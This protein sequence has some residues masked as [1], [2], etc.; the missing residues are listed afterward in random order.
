MKLPKTICCSLWCCGLVLALVALSGPNAARAAFILEIDT[1]GADDGILTFNPNFSFGGDTTTA[2]QSIPS[3]AYGMTGGDSIFGG[4]GGTLPD[5][6]VYTYDPAVD[7]D[8]LVIPPWQHLGDN[9]Y[10]TGNPG[11]LPGIYAVYVTWPIS[12]NV[13]GGDTRFSAATS[14]DG[15]VLDFDQNRGGAGTG[16]EWYKVG[17]ITWS[18]GP[19]TLTQQPTGGNTFVSMRA[20][21]ALFEYVAVPEPSTLVLLVLGAALAARRSL[22]PRA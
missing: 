18:S 17:E 16:H 22:R 12:S 14:S 20:A 13:S 1:D 19:I 10:A 4:N 7:V 5:T 2:S 6:Y 11:G 21:G 3:T 9:N 15:F 8:N